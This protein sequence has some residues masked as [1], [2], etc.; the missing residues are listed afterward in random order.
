MLVFVALLGAR[1]LL[2]SIFAVA[3]IA[4]LDDRPGS[5]QA[6]ID[7]GLPSPLAG[8]LG[9]LLPLAE[10]AVAAALVPAFTAYW[11]ALGALA[12]LLLFGCGIGAEEAELRES[13]L[14]G[15]DDLDDKTPEERRRIY[16]DLRLRVEIGPD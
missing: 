15:Y 7:F 8:L 9:L 10:L 5:R 2:A 3:A 16:L 11:G 13:I 4:K 14:A 12:L 1:L 6:I